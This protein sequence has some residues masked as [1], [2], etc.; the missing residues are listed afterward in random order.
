MSLEP[1]S[2]RVSYCQKSWVQSQNS[3]QADG[4]WTVCKVSG[5]MMMGMNQVRRSLGEQ[6]RDAIR[7][8]IISL[9]FVPG[10]MMYESE[11]ATSLGMSRTPVREAIRTLQ[12]EEL[13]EVLPQ[14]GLRVALISPTKVEEIRF[15]RESLELSALLKVVAEWDAQASR[16]RMAGHQVL[17]LL[18]EQRLAA[19]E[20][21]PLRFLYLDDD[22]HQL[23]LDQADN[24]TLISIVEQTRGHL[25]RVRMLGM[26]DLGNLKELVDEHV[27]LFHAVIG[28]DC[29]TV[30]ALSIKHLRRLTKDIS[31]LKEKFEAYFTA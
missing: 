6:A 18:E 21:D 13:I 28:N 22:F 2:R 25:N 20:S 23:L 14:R 10:Q 15:V 24:Q 4:V 8:S 30:R 3:F 5:A 29:D 7:E 12:V 11:L 17:S 27:R 9:K 16:Y 19:E 26:Q 31:V 1:S